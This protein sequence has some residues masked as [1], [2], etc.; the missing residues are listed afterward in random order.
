MKRY[1]Q[2]LWILVPLFAITLSSCS[3]GGNEIVGPEGPSI[4]KKGGGGKPPKDPPPPADPA[5][6]Y[7]GGTSLMVM[8]ADGTNQTEIFENDYLIGLPSW[9]PTGGSIV[10]ENWNSTSGRSEL[11][12]IDVSVVDSV[13]VGSNPRRLTDIDDCGGTPCVVPAWS[14]LGNEIATVSSTNWNAG[15]TGPLFVIPADGS[16]PPTAIYTPPPS[17]SSGPRD[18]AWSSDGNQIAFVETV[19]GTNTIIKI[20]NRLTSEVSVVLTESSTIGHLDWARHGDILAY[21]KR[22]STG[23]KIFTLNIGGTPEF[24]T[25]GLLPSWS[26]LGTKL[27]YHFP[28]RRRHTQIKSIDLTEGEITTISGGKMPD[29]R[30]F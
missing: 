7:I 27:V 13:P 12:V 3:K 30:R 22:D 9:S 11:W 25:D 21:R 14:P 4:L 24:I 2:Y 10:F 23:N 20:L 1:L 26:P 28:V 16:G 8:N 6:A 15:T 19:N 17:T 5:I 18:P 29:W